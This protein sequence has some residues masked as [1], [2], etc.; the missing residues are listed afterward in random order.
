[1]RTSMDISLYANRYVVTLQLIGSQGL[2][3]QNTTVNREFRCKKGIVIRMKSAKGTCTV[4][5]VA[6]CSG[7]AW[8]LPTP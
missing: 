5:A 6:G 2:L 4:K 7:A 3:L 8:R 1:M